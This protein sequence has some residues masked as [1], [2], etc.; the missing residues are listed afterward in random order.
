MCVIIKTSCSALLG[1]KV[2]NSTGHVV[3]AGAAQLYWSVTLPEVIEEVTSQG[4]GVELEYADA[5]TLAWEVELIK[6]GLAADYDGAVIYPNACRSF[7][8][9]SADAIFF[10]GIKMASGYLLMFIYTIFMLGRLNRLEVRLYL[11]IIG[12]I[13][14]GMGLIIGMGL[15]L[16]LGYP[17]TP[18]HAALPFIALGKLGWVL[19]LAWV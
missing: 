17:Y 10:D 19:S 12:I 16:A 7:G 15:T 18:R 1:H 13:C 8:D 3:A 9:V 14:I 5:L 11:S 2:Y 6:V 4:S